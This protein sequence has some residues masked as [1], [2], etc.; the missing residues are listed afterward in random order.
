MFLHAVSFTFK[1][2][3][4]H[5][6]THNVQTLSQMGKEWSDNNSGDEGDGADGDEAF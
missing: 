2:P 1:E 6:R 4:T 3:L 5:T